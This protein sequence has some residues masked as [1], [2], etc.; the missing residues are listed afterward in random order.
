MVE[1]LS[2]ILGLIFVLGGIYT[3]FLV[4]GPL[5][6]NQKKREGVERLRQSFGKMLKITGPILIIGGILTL[7]GILGA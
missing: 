5:P 1:N 2:K 4:Y 7:L 6:K 3:Q